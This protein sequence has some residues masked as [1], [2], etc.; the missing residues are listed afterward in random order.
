MLMSLETAYPFLTDFHSTLVMGLQG[1]GFPSL[2]IFAAKQNNCKDLLQGVKKVQRHH[3]V[4][5]E[6]TIIRT[7][8]KL[9]YLMIIRDNVY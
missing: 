9:E 6:V 7:L 8:D 3:S 2:P 4:T 5:S 1:S